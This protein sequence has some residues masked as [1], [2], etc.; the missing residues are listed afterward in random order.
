[1]RLR[2]GRRFRRLPRWQRWGL[3]ATL[4]VFLFGFVTVATAGFTSRARDTGAWGIAGLSA[5]PAPGQSRQQRAFASWDVGFGVEGS[6]G[7]LSSLRIDY[8]PGLTADLAGVPVG[9]QVGTSM[10][11][12]LAHP[13]TWDRGWE[14]TAPG[15]MTLLPPQPGEAARVLITYHPTLIRGVTLTEQSPLSVVASIRIRASDARMSAVVDGIPK[16][17]QSWLGDLSFDSLAVQFELFGRLAN[18]RGFVMNPDDRTGSGPDWNLTQVS[19]TSRRGETAV[20]SVPFIP[21]AGSV[22]V[23]PH[24]S[25][26]GSSMAAGMP[27]PLTVQIDLGSGRDTAQAAVRDIKVQLPGQ[28]NPSIADGLQGGGLVPCSPQQAGIGDGPPSCPAQSVI[29]SARVITPTIGVL[30]GTVNIATPPAGWRSGDPFRMFVL[31]AVPGNHGQIKVAGAIESDP[32]RGGAITATVRDLPKVPSTEIT[33]NLP[34]GPHTA[35]LAPRQAG[36]FSEALS[37]VSWPGELA[38]TEGKLTVIA[39]PRAAFAP[40]LMVAFGDGAP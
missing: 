32:S 39:G 15:V 26:P 29:G 16:I 33:I 8:R 11:D 25:F 27:S 35:I 19:T 37:V 3:T 1:M 10:V 21:D 23:V 40:S 18:G 17:A 4:V 38:A 31:L 14:V 24:L 34:A 5:G 9:T 2:I 36:T 13:T 20:A 30:T 22:S 6:A 12:V 7:E 28:L